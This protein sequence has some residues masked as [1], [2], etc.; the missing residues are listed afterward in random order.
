MMSNCS[1]YRLRPLDPAFDPAYRTGPRPART[2]RTTP[3]RS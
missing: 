3:V 2:T 1:L